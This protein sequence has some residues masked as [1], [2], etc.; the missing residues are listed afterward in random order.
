MPV[1]FFFFF[2]VRKRPFVGDATSDFGEVGALAV[3]HGGQ[4][5]PPLAISYGKVCAFRRDKNVYIV[6]NLLINFVFCI[7][8]I[9][10]FFAE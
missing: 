2:P 7:Y 6:A 1:I 9:F 3:E 10:F 4:V 8:C 5:T